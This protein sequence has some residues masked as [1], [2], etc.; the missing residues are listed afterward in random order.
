MAF[1][2]CKFTAIQEMPERSS[3]E[4][5]MLSFEAFDDQ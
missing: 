5:K 3:D 1:S 2:P 4:L